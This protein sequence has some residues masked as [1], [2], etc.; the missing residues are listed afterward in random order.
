MIGA[1]FAAVDV[2][3]LLL[4]GLAADFAL[5]L[6]LAGAFALAL[7]L[8]VDF[9]WEGAMTLEARGVRRALDT[10][11]RTPLANTSRRRA[12]DPRRAECR[13]VPV[14]GNYR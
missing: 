7:E 12:Q 11:K 14:S 1:V 8:A 3:V 6:E 5:N 2:D 4:L 10:D 9:D 13:C